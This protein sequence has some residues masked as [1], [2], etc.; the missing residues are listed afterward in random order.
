MAELECRD[1]LVITL[2]SPG[3][4]GTAWECCCKK[5]PSGRLAP[6][7]ISEVFVLMIHWSQ[8]GQEDSLDAVAQGRRGETVDSSCP[9]SLQLPPGPQTSPG[10]HPRLLFS[11]VRFIYRVV[12]QGTANWQG[13][14][15][16]SYSGFLGIFPSTFPTRKYSF[17]LQ[18]NGPHC[19]QESQGSGFVRL[20]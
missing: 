8:L 1:W 6:G 2:H 13:H 10:P 16:T 4:R 15:P 20:Q 3:W 9:A 18:Q 12:V 11:Q 19:H 14:S 17:S 5:Q 7:S